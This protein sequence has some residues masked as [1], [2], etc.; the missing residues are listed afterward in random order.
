MNFLVA[1]DIADA[2]RLR[3]VAK[4][5]ERNARRVQK[6]VF[7][8]TGTR[9]ELEGVIRELVKLI[10]PAEDRIQAWPIRTSSKAL[11]IDVGNALPDT[12]VTLIIASEE[13]TLIEAVD[14]DA[15]QLHDDPPLCVD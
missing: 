4:T 3:D 1:Y 5:L 13:C 6:S 2:K 14:D 9:R 10:E 8:F 11:R 15:N 12:A 7:V